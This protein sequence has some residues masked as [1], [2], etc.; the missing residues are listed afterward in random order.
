LIAGGTDLLLEMA[1]GQ[2]PDLETLIDLTRV[3][4]LDDIAAVDEGIEIGATATH[5]RVASSALV[6][7]RALPLAQA[8]LEI[9]SPQLR[10]RATIVGN[11]VTASP[12]NDTI[13]PLRALGTTLLIASPGG[14]RE[15]PL[16]GF[17][18]G[19]RQ[20]G[21]GPDEIVL[22]LRVRAMRRSERGVFV[23]LGLRRAQAISVIHMT[24]VLDF[25]GP[26]VRAASIAL[27]SVAP[28][29]IE[30]ARAQVF[31]VGRKLDPPTIEEASRLVG[32]AATP[33]DDIRA[34]AGYRSEQLAVL[35]RRALESLASATERDAWP[36]RIVTL[37][38]RSGG[39]FPTGSSHAVRADTG[40]EITAN[41]NGAPRTAPIGRGTLLDWLRDEAGLTG[42]KE[43]CAE[44]ECG[45]CTVFLDGMAVMSCLVPAGRGH[46]A[47]I[48]T[49]EGL[50]GP[51]GLHPLQQAFLDQGA[52][53][54]GFCIPGFIMSGAKLLEDG[55]RP[56][57]EDVKAALSGNLCRCTGY[58][59]IMAAVEQAASTGTPVPEDQ[60]AGSR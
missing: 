40:A 13:S 21:L 2:R 36:A 7:E 53:Q 1:R 28:T 27:G 50:A 35:S 14:R 39:R 22:G 25:D 12:A 47:E 48:V 6:I 54:C 23:K 56:T 57:I 30:A 11:V 37:A 46:G 60:P 52:V 38:G 32:A 8:C 20:I 31:L 16:A 29:I 55:F 26:T 51:E 19:V 15:A 42:S 5:G 43:G 10:N 49:I 17:H 34:S 44:G 4:G 58:Y 45:A 33:I 18:T 24:I 41:V 59:K 9:A 3:A